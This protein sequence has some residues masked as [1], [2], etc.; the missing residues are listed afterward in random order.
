[1]INFHTGI[2]VEYGDGDVVLDL[3][4][5]RRHYLKSWFAIDI[6]STLP[7]DYILQVRLNVSQSR[8]DMQR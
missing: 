1:M 7:I 3:Y 4:D 6:L 2:I 5:I 8:T